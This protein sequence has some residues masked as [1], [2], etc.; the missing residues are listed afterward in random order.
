MY[1]G[2]CH[3]DIHTAYGEWKIN[4]QCIT[5][6][7][8][9]PGHE[10]V[11]RVTEVGSDVT[12]VKV[13]D[14]VGVGCLVDSCRICPACKDNEEQHCENGS[15][16]TYCSPEKVIGGFTYGG[17]SS[18]FV[19]DEDFVIHIPN[20]LSES[21]AAVAP[22]LCAGITTYSPL[23][24]YGAGPGKTVGV[25]GLGGLGHMAVKLAKAMGAHVVL[26][27]TSANKVED[28]KA[29]GASEVIISKDPEQMK[30]MVNKIDLIIDTVSADHDFNAYLGLLR[31]N[32]SLILV[33]LP[34]REQKFAP[35]ALV[36]NNV[37]LGGSSIGGIK[38]T[39]EMIDF[40][41]KHNITSDIEIIDIKDVNKAYER[42]LK[43]D[44][45]YRFVIDNSTL[46]K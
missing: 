19:V 8:C 18:E 1:C 32:G 21:L 28:G 7:P 23:R 16:G 6:Y 36:H 4:G 34:E 11:G 3:S 37:H 40:C 41:A 24:R 10:I 46:K 20:S 2:I 42:V 39:Q 12:S 13:G 9:V 25:I 30:T 27:T 15:T 17:Y 22:L 44:V 35:F 5:T 43:S 29:L 38:E 31:R 33:G 14:L 26:F 45:K